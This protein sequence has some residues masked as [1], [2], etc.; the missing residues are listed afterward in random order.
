MISVQ[1]WPWSSFHRFVKVGVFAKDWG[2][3]TEDSFKYMVC[4]EV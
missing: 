4:G 3:S 1:G 2:K